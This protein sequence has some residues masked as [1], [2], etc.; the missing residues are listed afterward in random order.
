MK[1]DFLKKIVTILDVNRANVMHGTRT[2]DNCYGIIPSDNMSCHSTKLD[3][4]DLWHQRLG[5]INYK[6]LSTLTKKELIRGVPRLSRPSNHI[7]GPCQMGN[8]T[9]AIHKKTN[10]L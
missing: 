8:Q 5:H 2:S 4:I 10:L 7:C 6:E 9:R 3:E 1:L